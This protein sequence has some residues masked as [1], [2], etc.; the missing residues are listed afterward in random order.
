M[1]PPAPNGIVYH[2]R[3]PFASQLTRIRVSHDILSHLPTAL[4]TYH[5]RIKDKWIACQAMRYTEPQ[6]TP[7]GKTTFGFMFGVIINDQGRYH[8]YYQ[9]LGGDFLPTLD[10]QLFE[11]CEGVNDDAHVVTNILLYL[12]SDE[13]VFDLQSAPSTR[14]QR[15]DYKRQ[16]GCTSPQVF[17]VGPETTLRCEHNVRGHWRW[18]PHG[19]Q[20]SKLKLIWINSHTR[21]GKNELCHNVP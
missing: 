6:T 9:P 18:Q 8:F 20:L 15:D 11:H 7:S 5:I 17:L 1:P 3:E 10:T 2:F 4:H 12:F 19:P 21:G 16:Y 14:G 13:P